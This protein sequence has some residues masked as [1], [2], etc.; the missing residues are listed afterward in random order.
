MKTILIATTALAIMAAPAS[1]QLLGR[2]SV[3]GGLGS[4]LDVASTVT[5][6]VQTVQST[7]RS[8]TEG[9]ARTTGDQ[10][11]D[12]RSGRVKARRNAEASSDSSLASMADLPIG[13]IDGSASGSGRASGTGSANAQ[14][15]GTDDARGAATRTLDTA[16]SA[17]ATG[18]A[19]AAPAASQA[20]TLPGKAGTLL[21]GSASGSSAANGEA[22]TNPASGAFAASGSAAAM[23]EGA[24]AVAPGMP[25]YSAEGDRIGKV[26]QVVA[27]R[28]GE[29][30][31]I[32]VK[33]REGLRRIPVDQL[34]ASAN[35][36][37]LVMAEGS[38]SSP[39]REPE[40]DAE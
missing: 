20:R 38:A 8:T 40:P 16:R 7:T 25:V 36:R 29:V 35:G 12:R 4:N 22:A 15:I 19:L 34:S 28:R 11:V 5:R 1:A 3:T 10:S 32:I 9:S 13:S 2:G 26:R 27:S 24:L 18:Q 23:A 37:G 31:Q 6:G 33:E 30:Q 17:S 21:G 14:L 39:P